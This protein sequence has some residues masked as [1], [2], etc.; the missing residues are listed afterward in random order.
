MVAFS[1]DKVEL[2]NGDLF[3]ND[4]KADVASTVLNQY[5][6]AS[7]EL[8]ELP[9]NK[10]EDDFRVVGRDSGL[11]RYQCA[12]T[13]AEAEEYRQRKPAIVSVTRLLDPE[14]PALAF[15]CKDCQHSVDNWGPFII[16]GPGDT[17]I[18]DN[19]EQSA[20]RNISG[21][22]NGK[23]LVKEKLYFVLGDNRHGAMDSRFIGL[24]TA[25]K[26]YGIV[27]MKR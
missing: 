11:Y 10:L 26:M 20:F 14:L 18:V 27:E 25:S 2:K 19:L 12:F 1:G 13:A 5:K 9:D 16:P 8:L 4:R 22:H 23:N 24:I 17:V 15:Y 7:T 3:I 21:V 6:V